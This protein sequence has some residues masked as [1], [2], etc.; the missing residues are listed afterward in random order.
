M[1][2][3]P[4]IYYRQ[5]TKEK[6]KWYR[7]VHQIALSIDLG[8]DKLDR[9]ALES[10][11]FTRFTS[12]R[13]VSRSR[14][15]HVHSFFF[16]FHLQ[17]LSLWVFFCKSAALRTMLVKCRKHDAPL[18]IC[19]AQHVLLRLY[20]ACGLIASFLSE[21][22]LSFA[23]FPKCC[24]AVCMKRIKGLGRRDFVSIHSA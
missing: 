8:L 15:S 1:L 6:W 12:H 18:S 21:E 5:V 10:L 11:L 13:R 16:F 22:I 24:F 9:V 2:L 4:S 7:Y 20:A 19:N 17:I 14:V 3:R 23:L